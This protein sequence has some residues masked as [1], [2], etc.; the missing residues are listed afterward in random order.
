MHC[1]QC[2][3]ICLDVSENSHIGTEQPYQVSHIACLIVGFTYL[4][5]TQE[6]QWIKVILD[7]I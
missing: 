5:I 7:S 1:H 2:S 3:A 6:Q 4:L